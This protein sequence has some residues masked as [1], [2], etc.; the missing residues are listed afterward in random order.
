MKPGAGSLKTS[1][2]WIKLARLN[3]ERE[4]DRAQTKS[5]VKEERGKRRNNN[6]YHKNTNNYRRIL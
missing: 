5:Q 3:K 2:K 6:Q 1:T 4:R